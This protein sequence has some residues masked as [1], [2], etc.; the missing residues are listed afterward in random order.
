[1]ERTRSGPIYDG[2]GHIFEDREAIVS[3]MPRA[4]REARAVS[5][6]GPIP[7]L[8]NY[9]G[10][11]SITPEGS[12]SNPD[13]AAGWARFMDELSIGGAALYPTDALSVGR[14]VDRDQAI[15]LTRAYNDWLAEEYLARDARL[16]GL[17]LIPMQEPDAAVREL[18]RA[19]EDLG[20]R[21]AMLPATG[22]PQHHGAKTYWPV[23]E[24]ADR[25]GCCL[26]IHGGAYPN[27]GFNDLNVF[28]AIHAMGH[29]FG[30]TIGFMS[31]LFNG[32]FDKFPNVRYGFMEGGV[33]WFLMALER[34]DGSYKAF[35]PLDPRGEYVRLQDGES[36]RDYIARN[37]KEGRLYVGVEGDE[38]DLAHAVR[39]VGSEAFVWSS[40]FPHEVNV[41]TCGDELREMA[42]NPE[43]SDDDLDAILWRNAARL[44]AAPA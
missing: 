9:H 39:T 8:D 2:D 16:Q 17:A 7:E 25:L 31:L 6:I 36:V 1:M 27:L 5:R 12:F 29:P 28:A 4:W 43:L 34:A 42:E 33:G 35:T 3:R 24:E 15:A 23:Y 19:V 37:V 18:R 40:D 38:P 20:M 44:Y 41:R 32:V 14:M 21:G 26:S 10:L 30:I 11:L 22:L 13:G